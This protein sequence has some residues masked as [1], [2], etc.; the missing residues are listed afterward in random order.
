MSGVDSPAFPTPEDAEETEFRL[1][2]T[3]S[4]ILHIKKNNSLRI[5][6]R[7]QYL[8]YIGRVYCF[9]NTTLFAKSRR[10]YKRDPKI[11]IAKLLRADVSKYRP[12]VYKS[13]KSKILKKIHKVALGKLLT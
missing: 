1:R 11:N 2:Y 5:V 4:D 10:P 7:S 6:I 13:E 9:P 8:K 12:E 3:N